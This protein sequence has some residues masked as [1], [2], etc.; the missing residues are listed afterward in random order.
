MS[1]QHTTNHTR[2]LLSSSERAAYQIVADDD[3]AWYHEEPRNIFRGILAK[4]PPTGG[5]ISHKQS[6]AL[7]NDTEIAK[8]VRQ[9]KQEERDR[10]DPSRQHMQLVEKPAPLVTNEAEPERIDPMPDQAPSPKLTTAEDFSDHYVIYKQL[11]QILDVT[12]VQLEKLLLLP[13]FPPHLE[14]S[15]STNRRSWLWSYRAVITWKA[16][17]GGMIAHSALPKPRVKITG[18]ALQARMEEFERRLSAVEAGQ[19]RRESA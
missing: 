2:R 13:K 18:R 10:R 3:D 9:W 19:S 17:N 15:D 4:V 6:L 12:P 1:G 7:Y 11:L 5:Y 16:A 14:G 8:S